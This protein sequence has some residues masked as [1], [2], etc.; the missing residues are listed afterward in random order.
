MPC[1]LQS[2]IISDPMQKAQPVVTMNRLHF[3][4]REDLEEYARSIVSLK[5]VSEDLLAKMAESVQSIL[6]YFHSEADKIDI[7][8][9]EDEDEKLLY[10]FR[11]IDLLDYV[12]YLSGENWSVNEDVFLS[13]V[14]DGIRRQR[15][16]KK[17]T[18]L[19]GVVPYRFFRYMICDR[20]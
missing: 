8:T 18:C 20:A 19:S 4:T 15:N 12:S 5:P 2:E 1:L 7:T 16:R 14:L 13:C 17:G 9:N 6:G 3:S 10:L 11:R